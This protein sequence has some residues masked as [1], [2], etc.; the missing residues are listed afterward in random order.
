MVVPRVQL[1]ISASALVKGNDWRINLV[2]MFLSFLV[3]PTV[4]PTI[5]TWSVLR[6]GVGSQALHS[7]PTVLLAWVECREVSLHCKVNKD[8]S[9]KVGCD[10]PKSTGKKE[11]RN[12]STQTA[13]QL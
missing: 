8:S 9:A 2:Y 11:E 3:N 1:Q 13:N 7:L 4:S 5:E 6:S 10:L 12:C